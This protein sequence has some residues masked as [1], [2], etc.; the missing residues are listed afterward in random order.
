M[1]PLYVSPLTPP[2]KVRF[3]CTK[4]DKRENSQVFIRSRHDKM[5]SFDSEEISYKTKY[6]DM[7]EKVQT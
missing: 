4:L 1:S 2:A 7:M 3:E 5:I 6:K